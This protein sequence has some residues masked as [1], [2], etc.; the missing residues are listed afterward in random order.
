VK[1]DLRMFRRV[2]EVSGFE[3][4]ECVMVGDKVVD[5]IEPAKRIGM[6]AILFTDYEQLK[7]DMRKLGISLRQTK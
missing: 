1:P 5:D 7:M 3:P 6:E 2:L 4:G